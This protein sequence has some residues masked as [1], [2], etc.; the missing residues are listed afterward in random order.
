MKN[1][2]ISLLLDLCEKVDK[3][4]GNMNLKYL[5]CEEKKKKRNK[6]KLVPIMFEII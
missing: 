4:Y 3:W 1:Q 2:S 5:N 6:N